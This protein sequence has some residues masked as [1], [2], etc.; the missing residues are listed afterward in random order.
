M[1]YLIIVTG[2]EGQLGQALQKAYQQRELGL[3]MHFLSRRELDITQN[4]ALERY[5]ER[6]GLPPEEGKLLLVNC[7]AYTQVEQAEADVEAAYQVNQLGVRLLSESLRRLGGSL[8]HISTDMVFDGK[9][10]SAYTEEDPAH[11]LSVY[12]KSKRAGEKEAIEILWEAALILRTSWLYSSRADSFPKK[13]ERVLKER[14]RASVIADQLGSPTYAPHL[15]E[16]LTRIL[17]QFLEEGAFPCQLLHYADRGTAS[18]YDFAAATQ[19]LERGSAANIQ[20]IG[21]KEFPSQVERPQN[22]SL[23]G[24]LYEKLYQRERKHW[25]EGIKAYIEDKK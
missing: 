12:G 19:L 20:P 18:W 21:H 13:I 11:P 9:K 5:L 3:N 8:I 22:S 23:S 16:A 10:G 1:S 15:A 25:L 6:S 14:G 17:E 24:S 4:R 2:A 7:A